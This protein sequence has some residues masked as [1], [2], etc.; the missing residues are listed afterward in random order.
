M[1][2]EGQPENT[3]CR[4]VGLLATK[5]IRGLKGSSAVAQWSLE[6]LEV[7][8]NAELGRILKKEKDAS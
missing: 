1:A 5:Q 8:L 3:K 4:I 7:L 6:A 2:T